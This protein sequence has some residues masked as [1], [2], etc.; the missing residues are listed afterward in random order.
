[1]DSALKSESL[2]VGRLALTSVEQVCEHTD[3]AESICVLNNV[4]QQAYIAR[5]DPS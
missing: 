4:L 1:M 5:R 3:H 2:V